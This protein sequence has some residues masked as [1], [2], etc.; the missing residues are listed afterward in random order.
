MPF[1]PVFFLCFLF[2][3]LL[4]KYSRYSF[5]FTAIVA[6]LVIAKYFLQTLIS[7]TESFPELV[8]GIELAGDLVLR[9]YLKKAVSELFARHLTFRVANKN[10]E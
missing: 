10:K 5:V 2:T 7:N 1:E 6:R 8:R 9:H 4:S 3:F